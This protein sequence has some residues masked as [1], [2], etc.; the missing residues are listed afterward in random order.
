MEHSH[1]C[2]VPPWAQVR[3][4]A[5]PLATPPALVTQ[6]QQRFLVFLCR[7]VITRRAMLSWV[8][9]SAARCR[10]VA[11]FHTSR[12][13]VSTQCRL[14]GGGTHGFAGSRRGRRRPLGAG[15]R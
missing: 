4:V 14:Y 15:R 10:R 8:F 9:L 12:S 13:R 3:L 6:K 1:D 5:K 7:R 11:V 2:H